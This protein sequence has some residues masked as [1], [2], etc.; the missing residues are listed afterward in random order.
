GNNG[1]FGAPGAMPTKSVNNTNY[2]RD[3]VFTSGSQQTLLGSMMPLSTSVSDGSTVRYELGMKFTSI[4]SG[5]ISAIR[6]YKSPSETGQHTG[7]IYSATGSLLASVVF[8]NETASGYQQQNLPTPLAIT[9]NTVYV[10][11]VNTGGSYY[12]KTDNGM[13]NQLSSASLRSIV[14]N[15]GVFG[16]P[17]A[18][19]T[20]SVNNTN[21]FRDVVFTSGS[22]GSTAP[23][24]Q[25]IASPAPTPA[26]TPTP[27][28][29]PT[30]A[31]AST[32]ASGYTV[33]TLV[34]DMGLAND[35]PV[36]INPGAPQAGITM[37]LMRGD[38]VAAW[39]PQSYPQVSFLV[40]ANTYWSSTNT[41]FVVNSAQGNKDAS[42]Y[43]EL[44]NDVTYYLYKST[45][46][47]KAIN[48]P[49]EQTWAANFNGYNVS[50]VVQPDGH[51]SYAIPGN[52][53]Q[54]IHGG[55]VGGY[56]ES[57]PS[58]VIAVHHRLEAR[59]VMSNPASFDLN[60][61]RRLMQV[62]EDFIPDAWPKSMPFYMGAGMS[63]CRFLT[64]NW[65]VFTFTT[66]KPNGS[67]IVH[68]P[69]NS[70]LK[71]YLTEDELRANP[72]PGFSP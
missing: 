9:A 8:S 12:V 38:A 52:A 37:G 67:N 64:P 14:G 18:M 41:W 48:A 47:W 20:K 42:S 63:R 2:F 17:G 28:P 36:G 19:P 13:A 43:V 46:Q 55:A 68:T 4:T 24:S 39:L 35:A 45:G 16:A 1:V 70:S 31:P 21:Y 10:V 5:T 15:N 3:V 57:N 51:N 22:G 34:D 71:T 66:V 40:N 25:P 23:I 56:R 61:T 26:P 49:M 7:K 58:D 54:Y 62:G 50:M 72:P 30:P 29:S 53:D 33:Q 11:S 32:G 65:Q 69:F 27:K 59:L 44:R 6:F 60:Y